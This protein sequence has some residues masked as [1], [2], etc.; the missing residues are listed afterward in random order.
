MREFFD[1]GIAILEFIKKRRGE[2]FS[3]RG[4]HLVGIEIPIVIIPNKS[5]NNV[6]FNGFI[7]LVM[8]NENTESL[9]IYD[10]K[11]STRGWSDREKKDE[12]KIQQILLYQL[13][14]IHIL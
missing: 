9:T 5:Y 6:L 3:S 4:W 13:I 8:Y 10:I 2:Y 12:N 1:D 7:D 11:T 14:Q